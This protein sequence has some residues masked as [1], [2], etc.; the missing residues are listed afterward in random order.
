[1]NDG[2]NSCSTAACS[3]E[4]CSD[5]IENQDETGVDCGGVCGACA[6]PTTCS[7]PFGNEGDIRTSSAEA[8]I[9]Q[10][11][12]LV[13][14]YP[15]GVSCAVY[16][17]WETSFSCD[18]GSWTDLGSSCQGTAPSIDCVGHFEDVGGS[19]SV[20]GA[21]GQSG[22]LDEVY[23]IDTPASGGGDSCSYSSGFTRTATGSS[24]NTATCAPLSCTWDTPGDTF[25]SSYYIE[26]TTCSGMGPDSS[27]K[28][29]SCS[30]EGQTNFF[31]MKS[32]CVCASGMGLL[33]CE[34]GAQQYRQTCTC[35]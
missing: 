35:S 30:T 17:D 20:S 15:P 7:G 16:Y 8:T 12:C 31:I 6:A 33:S 29:G 5:G 24:C 13:D 28:T 22:N 4:T 27:F 23:V 21:C 1:V 19:C 26:D 14:D 32:G 2:G 34:I 3:G 18:S 10:C 9:G 11:G 25:G